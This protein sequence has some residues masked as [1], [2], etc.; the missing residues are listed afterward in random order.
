MSH[1]PLISVVMAVR[2]ETDRLSDSVESILNQNNVTLE[3]IIV[4]DG[5]T[6]DSRSILQRYSNE[7]NRIRLFTQDYQGLTR[8]LVKGCT[9]ARGE[10]ITRQDA[11]DTSMPEK[12]KLEAAFLLE[13]PEVV[14]VSCGTRFVGPEG[15]FVYDVV[16]SE[17][18]ARD[19]IG[20]L[21][22]EEIR[23]PS[24]HGSVMFW[25]EIYKRVG[26]YRS[27]FHVA[28]DL[29]LWTRMVEHGRHAALQD[30]LYV[31][32]LHPKSISARSRRRQIETTAIIVECAR[33]RRR[34]G[35]DAH[36]LSMAERLASDERRFTDRRSR[37]DMFYFL[38]SCSA[39]QNKSRARSYFREALRSNPFHMKALIRYVSTTL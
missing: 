8:A 14:L 11:G 19:C 24:H 33:Q 2:N 17:D 20:R 35:D 29:D 31:A 3:F 37:A 1:L 27:Q 6:D 10:F 9:H 15:E 22:L 5:S 39:C 28:Q 30:V 12:L 38:G 18:E 21:S 36:L 23:G 4:D 7:D 34:G 13:N 26:G 16:Q 25:R 32:Q